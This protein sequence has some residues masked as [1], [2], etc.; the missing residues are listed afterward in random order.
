MQVKMGRS[1]TRALTEG[2]ILA[3]ITVVIGIIRFYMPLFFILSYFWAVPIIIV[4][5]RHGF[6]VSIISSIVASVLLSVFTQPVSGLELFISF[7][8]PGVVMGYMLNRK[9]KPATVILVSGV[10]LAICSAVGIVLTTMVGG[11]KLFDVYNKLFS[12]LSTAM[13]QSMNQAGQ[14]YAQLGISQEEMA[15]RMPPVDMLI[16]LLKLIVPIMLLWGGMFFAFVNF[17]ATKLVLKRIGHEFEDITP[18]SQWRLSSRM[19]NIIVVIL[20]VIAAE[21]FLLKLPALA[22]LTYNLFYG[23]III[24]LI[25]GLSTAIFMLRKYSVPKALRIFILILVALQFSY[26]LAIIGVFDT[27]FDFRKLKKDSLNDIV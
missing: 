1:N 6:R 22:S 18:F 26:L 21:M 9:I 20:L 2:A 3:A 12:E 10:V 17:K 13:T 23:V 7:A 19:N 27:A 5:I 24:Y 15:K 4:G 14:I 16:S 11:I 25:L 8:L